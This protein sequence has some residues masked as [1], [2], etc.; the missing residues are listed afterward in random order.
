MTSVGQTNIKILFNQ[1]NY[2]LK[3]CIVENGG[4]HLIGNDWKKS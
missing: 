4:P 3:L 2:N 1:N